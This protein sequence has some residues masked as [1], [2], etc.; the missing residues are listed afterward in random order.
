MDKLI[1]RIDFRDVGTDNLQELFRREWL[2]TN[3]LGG[4]ASGTISGSVSWRYHGLLIAALPEPFGRMVMLNQLA[5]FAHLPSGRVIEI[6]G[7][8]KHDDGKHPHYVTEFRL[9]N[10]LPMWR[11]EVEGVIIE[12]HILF[13]YGQN[14]VHISYKLLSDQE[15][16][17]LELRPSI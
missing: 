2:V 13:L 8:E 10:H 1:R 6:G 17:R 4:Y 9:E 16:V 14:T 3:G 15:R 7:E 11:Y 12:K 5:E